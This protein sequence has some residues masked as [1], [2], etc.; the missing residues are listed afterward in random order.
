[1]IF[2]VTD[3]I[4]FPGRRSWMGNCIIATIHYRVSITSLANIKY[5]CQ[6]KHLPDQDLR[7]ERGLRFEFQYKQT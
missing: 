6:F 2:H 5:L 3:E 1:M 4:I 7:S